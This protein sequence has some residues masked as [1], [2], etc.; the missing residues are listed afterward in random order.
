MEMSDD[1]PMNDAKEEDGQLPINE[2][3]E[4]SIE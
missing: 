3:E 4:D 2:E 1:N